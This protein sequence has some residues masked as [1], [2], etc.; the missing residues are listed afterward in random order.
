[1]LPPNSAVFIGCVGKD[2][3][4]DILQEENKR[5]GLR[6][7]YRYDE[8][9][10]T[11]KC[12]VVITGHNRSMCTHLAAANCYKI[13]HL[14]ENWSLVEQAKVYFVGGYHLTVSVPAVL[15]LAEE[16]AAKNK[17]SS[18]FLGS[19][20]SLILHR[21]RGESATLLSSASQRERRDHKDACNSATGVK[22]QSSSVSRRFVAT[23][24]LQHR[25]L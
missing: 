22:W 16:A 19:I 12:A 23:V 15:A 14:K 13:E 11:G 5:A 2:K 1:M 7:E 6:A 9:E 25:H 10:P 8:K 3:Y 24:L 4:A 21:R 18:V 20:S 17:V